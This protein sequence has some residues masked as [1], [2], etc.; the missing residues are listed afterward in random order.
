MTK[1]N[2]PFGDKPM[3]PYAYTVTITHPESNTTRSFVA[4]RGPRLWDYRR[5]PCLY[6]G[7]IHGGPA[8]EVEKD[9][10]VIEGKYT[11]YRVDDLF[12]IYLENPDFSKYTG[13]CTEPGTPS[14]G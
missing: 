9:G 5:K 13:N 3:S 2:G 11:D 6:A 7:N 14:P 10:S 4:H 12:S 8:G 1:Y